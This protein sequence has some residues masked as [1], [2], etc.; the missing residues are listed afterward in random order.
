M[1]R[2]I[3]ICILLFIAMMSYSVVSYGQEIEDTS[4]EVA[5]DSVEAVE[6]ESI[7][8]IEPVTEGEEGLKKFNFNYFGILYGPSIQNP[9]SFQPSTDGTPDRDR[10]VIL[11]NFLNLGYNVTDHVTVTGSGYWIWEPVMQ[12]QTILQDPFLRVSHNSIFSTD[13][14]NLYG[15]FRVHFPVTS[16]SRENDMKFGL[17]TVQVLTYAV[18]TTRLTLGAFGS[19]RYNSFGGMGYGNDLEL[20]AAPNLNYQI[21]PTVALTVLYEMQTSHSFGERPFAFSNDG[22]DIE[23]G[24]SWDIRPNLMVNPYLH[25]PVGKKATFSSTSFGMMLNWALI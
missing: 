8:S 4:V 24:I 3:Q 5:A 19:A 18:G 17:Q 15:D 25:F 2:M 12:H 10:P 9:T 22:M 16:I 13:Q 21:T 20:Y 1:D 14:A 23:P 7:E 6:N 11:K